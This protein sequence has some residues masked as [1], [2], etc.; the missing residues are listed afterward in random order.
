[1][2]KIYLPI[3]CVFV[4]RRRTDFFFFGFIPAKSFDVYWSERKKQTGYHKKT[5]SHTK[6]AVQNV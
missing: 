5:R 3:R 1:M 4:L 2:R 6:K